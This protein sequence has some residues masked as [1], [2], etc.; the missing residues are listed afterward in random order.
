M[1]KKITKPMLKR[2]EKAINEWTWEDNK[3]SKMQKVYK[4][5]REDLQA[6][7]DLIVD[8]DNETAGRVASY[9]DTIVRDQIPNDVWGLL[10]ET[11]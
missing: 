9:L 3:N 1:K 6:V 7:Y 11:K 5:D 8:G 10:M 2:F 4:K